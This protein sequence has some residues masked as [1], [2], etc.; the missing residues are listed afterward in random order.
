MNIIPEELNIIIAAMQK[1][2][3]A[4]E[5]LAAAARADGDF[6]LARN[7]GNSAQVCLGMI[8]LLEKHRTGSEALP[9]REQQ[10]FFIVRVLQTTAHYTR[11]AADEFR[12]SGRFD[13]AQMDSAF[14]AGCDAVREKWTRE[15]F[16]ERAR[17]I[18]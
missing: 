14:A 7:H 4:F 6:K 9:L 10:F 1:S 13:Q 2:Q 18:H 11:E 12:R 8:E 15:G 17:L 5:S 3:L 16:T